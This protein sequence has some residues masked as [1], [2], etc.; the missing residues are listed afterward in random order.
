MKKIVYIAGI[1]MLACSTSVFAQGNEIDAYTLSNTELSGTARSMAM[2][3]AFGALGGDISVLSTNP[4]GLGIYRSSEISGTFDL[5]TASSSTNWNG[6]KNN[7]SR[8]GFTLD[9]FGFQLY[10][11]T[12]SDGGIMNWNL[13]FSFNR[14]KNFN[15]KY[16]M[17]SNGQD[18]SLADYTA[19]KASYIDERDLQY[20]K[21][22]YDPYYN[23]NLSGQW[24]SVLGYEAG[25]FGNITG[26]GNNI[27]HNAFGRWNGDN[28]NIS[29]P[30]STMLA[31]TESGSV[32]EYNIGLGTNILNIVFLGTSLSFTEINYRMTSTYDEQFKSAPNMVGRVETDD[33]YLDNRLNTEG[34]AVS[35]NVGAI[36]NL[37]LLRLGVA[38]NS[39]RYYNMTDYYNADAGSYING[40]D[41]PE[42]KSSTPNDSYSE[43]SFR[44]PDKWTFSAALLFG[45][46][47]LVSADY[48]LTN[49]GK[50]R[51]ADRDGDDY[52]YEMNKDIKSD[53]SSSNALRL[54]VE[55][56]VTPRLAIRAG[57]ATQ[58]SP[59]SDKLVNNDVEVMPS[60]TIPHFTTSSN[61][62]NYYTLGF[63]YRFTPNIFMDFAYILRKYDGKA[64][65]FSS[66]YYKDYDFDVIS[67]PASLTSS[68]TRLALTL[69]YK[70]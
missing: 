37:E 70:F 61:A 60:G 1:L 52:G 58:L 46:F 39:P 31:V 53:F 20:V 8:T 10:F 57:Y 64:Y 16:R 9:N 48:E 3:G 22:E 34:S 15:R 49:Y 13:G 44:S 68:S 42:A 65:A 47:A 23:S 54:G 41:Q 24:L 45:Q 12:G 66:T 43:Y 50:M 4:A 28:W 35:I 62:V 6:M 5:S 25:M 63:G 19:S 30:S 56:K 11:P 36:V 67:T 7:L 18:F 51:F 17:E 55:V 27:Y 21:D 2:G 26:N 29:G 32:D 14:L 59:M 33:L 38:Y 69:G 40:Y